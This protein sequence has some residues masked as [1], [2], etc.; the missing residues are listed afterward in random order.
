MLAVEIVKIS[1][2]FR[3]AGV[4]RFIRAD[5]P[6]LFAALIVPDLGAIGVNTRNVTRGE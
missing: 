5:K 1:G 3:Q 6:P 2:R 4:I